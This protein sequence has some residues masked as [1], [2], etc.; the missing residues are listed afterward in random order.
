MIKVCVADNFPVV[1]YGIKSFFKDH[2][3]ISIVAN[4]GNFSMLKEILQ[5]KEIDVLLLDLELEGLKSIFEVKAILKEFPE[6]KVIIYS[7]LSEQIY[8][9][10]SIKAGVS[11]FIHKKEKLSVIY[12]GIKQVTD[13]KI[14]MNETVKKN[15]AL[16]AK[17]SKSERIYRKLSNR[18]VEVLR[19]LSDGKK[20]HEIADILKLNE[21]TISTYK[22]RLLTKL[23]VTNLVDLVNKAKTLEIV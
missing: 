18:E 14:V 17:K 19:Y 8:A 3:D 21:K 1:H 23:N 6:T 4:I 13:G 16:I 12:D 9:P 5:S 7:N 2:S 11:G 20:N 22:L 10:N 15:L